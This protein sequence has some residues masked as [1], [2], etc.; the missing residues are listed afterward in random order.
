MT[1]FLLPRGKTYRYDFRWRPPGWPAGEPGKRETGSTG[2]TEKVDA[3]LVE[4][5]VMLRLRQEAHGIAPFDR[6]RTPSFT[7]W[8]AVH[9]AHTTK[10]GR[11]TRID[12]FKSDL[13]MVLQFWGKRPAK[14]R[15]LSKVPKQWR[16]RIAQVEA[17][18]KGAPYRD[19]RLADPI[20]R[21][22]LI[23]EFEDW[24]TSLGLSGARKNHYRSAMSGLY[25][26]A[27]LPAYRR[28]ANV[29]QNPF[30]HLERDRVPSRDAV[31][32]L[33]QL[34]AWM[35]AA[36]PHARVAMAI[37]AYAPELRVASILQLE[38][39]EHF[40]PELTRIV[41]R[42]HKTAQRTGRPQVIPIPVGLQ[43]ILQWVREQK[44]TA[45]YV[46][47]YRDE[48]VESLK[49]GLRNAVDRANRN[50]PAEQQIT[51]GVRDAG[52]TFHAIRH[53]IATLLA[54][55]G[56]PEKIRQMV[57]GHA[58]PQT[59]QK[60]THMAAMAKKQPLARLGRRLQLVDAVVEQR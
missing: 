35:K 3:D 56:V 55:W 2:Q 59:T 37:A 18:A 39:R 26:T 7:A 41:V 11:V 9:L 57:M 32:T 29:T 1:T 48:P 12:A 13:R 33:E 10:K 5:Q 43:G 24:M 40:D 6:M 38:W 51:Y 21:P 19:L 25:R 4:A 47:T 49:T 34:R 15:D 20:V 45:R 8:A 46:I 52:V 22:E 58:S 50:L 17:R 36:A 54:D 28:K 60:Y 27:L 53:T 23:E 16:T 14:A 44:P 42:D 30:V 31:L